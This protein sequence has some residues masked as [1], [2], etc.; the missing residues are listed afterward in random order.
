MEIQINF[1]RIDDVCEV[2]IYN[3]IPT[4]R[5]GIDIIVDEVNFYELII[6]IIY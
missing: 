6:L 3:L 4:K 2:K 1:N 5:I